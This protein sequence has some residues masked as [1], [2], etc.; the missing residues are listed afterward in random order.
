MTWYLIC[1][2]ILGM[3]SAN[4]RRRYILTSSFI[5]WT[6]TQFLFLFQVVRVDLMGWAPY[7]IERG[8]ATQCPY[9]C[10]FNGYAVTY[11]RCTSC[12]QTDSCNTDDGST[13]IR[14][15]MTV[16]AGCA[17]L[18][19]WSQRYSK[20]WRYA[21]NTFSALLAL[22]VGNPLWI[23]LTQGQWCGYF[24]TSLLLARTSCWT[25]SRGARHLKHYDAHVTL[26]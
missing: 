3:G 20:W 18:F 10:K 13:Q 24:M 1:E 4:E 6:H 16:M 15:L 25:S 2:C 8:C 17:M 9:G 5:D 12:C 21:M 19:L 23:L 14:P 22:Y 7:S 26:L 11:M